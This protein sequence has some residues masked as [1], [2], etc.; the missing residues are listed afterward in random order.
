M[1]STEDLCW[2]DSPSVLQECVGRLKT[3]NALGVDAGIDIH[4]R[5]HKPMAKQLVALLEPHHPLFIQDPL[6]SENLEGIKALSL[7]TTQHH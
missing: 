3:V 7:N 5:V 2:L 6:L 1:N 4:G